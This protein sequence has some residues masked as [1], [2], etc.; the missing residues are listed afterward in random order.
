MAGRYRFPHRLVEGVIR[1][2]PNRF[3]M[4]VELGGKAVKCHCPS[5]GRIGSIRFLNVPCLL[6]KSNDPKRKMPYTVE[7]F[8]LD[9]PGKKAKK[10]IGINQVQANRYVEHYLRQGAM[11]IIA[12]RGA[13]V[14]RERKVGKSRIDFSVDGSKF[15]EVKTMLIHIPCE[16]HP[17]YVEPGGEFHGMDRMIRHFRDL[18][19]SVTKGGKAVLLMCFLYDAAPFKPPAPTKNTGAIHRAARKAHGQGMEYWQANF[20]VDEQGVKLQKY[21]PLSLFD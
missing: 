13:E 9:A 6:S 1:A 18:G 20:K 15:V 12:R 2:R 10:W 11:P 5:T 16:G 4:M 19:T 3:I 8:S 17:D 21:F 7:A 14:R